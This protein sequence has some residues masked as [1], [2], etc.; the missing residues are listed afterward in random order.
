MVQTE[1]QLSAL[2][3]QGAEVIG[4]SAGFP[5]SGFLV[6]KFFMQPGERR[7]GVNRW[8]VISALGSRPAEFEGPT[9]GGTVS[10][11][12]KPPGALTFFPIGE[13]PPTRLR[14]R[15]E[16]TS[17]A[18]NEELVESIRLEVDGYRSHEL[19]YRSGLRDDA[20]ERIVA[21]LAIEMESGGL[22]GS[23][24]AESLIRAL[25]CRYIVLASEG[26][27]STLPAVGAMHPRLLKRLREWMEE[28][29]HRDISLSA[30]AK[31]TKYSSTHLL[32][33][34]RASTGLTP[35]QYLIDLRIERAQRL[36]RKRDARLID[37]AIECGFSSQA[38]LTSAFK[39]RRGMTPGQYQRHCSF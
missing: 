10:T 16:L 22:S 21:L 25:V 12:T 17:C 33:I 35:H 27:Q 23:L 15:S 28:N 20:A 37:V 11:Y 38:H 1:S 3:P 36:L 7:S 6:E 32:R 9:S 34:F 39:A 19:L 24:Y 26:A 30:M 18:V 4:T 14:S 5:W 13:I 2:L 31:E 29:A 8:H